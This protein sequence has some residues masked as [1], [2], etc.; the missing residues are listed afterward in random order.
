MWSWKTL[1]DTRQSTALETEVAR[2]ATRLEERTARLTDLESELEQVPQLLA[3]RTRLEAELAAEKRNADE[4]TSLLHG[5]EAVLRAAAEETLRRMDRTLQ[6]VERERAVSAAGLAKQLE[7]IADSH[8]RLQAETG[9]LAKA[10]SAPTV[11]GRWGE[12]QLRRVIEMAGMLEHCDFR[13]QVSTDSEEGMLRPDVVVRLPG[14][15]QVV[16]DAKAPLPAMDSGEGDTDGAPVAD[17][18]RQVRDHMTRLGAKRYWSQFDAS[19]EFVV[20]F[21]PGESV[22]AGA[23]RDDATLL[24]HGVGQR[25]LPAS[26]TTL[27]ALLRATAY[28]WQQERLANNV[29]EIG[30]TGRE[31][32]Q[33]LATL[34]KHFAGLGRGLGRAVSEYNRTVDLLETKILSGAE[35]LGKLGAGTEERVPAVAAIATVPRVRTG[36][37]SVDDLSNELG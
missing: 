5:G 15:R 3:A 1:R 24:D 27:I 26:P 14:G 36:E 8:H 32:Y 30:T 21:L 29:E 18:A 20:M 31:L 2:L 37:A 13:E 9:N 12:M 25:V 7:T 11:R 34:T 17:Y 33:R 22:F 19:P 35:R 28:G 4:R 10:L 6:S 23:L 16:I